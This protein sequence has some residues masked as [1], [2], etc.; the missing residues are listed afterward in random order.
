V[1]W[2]YG[3]PAAIVLFT[4]AL[5][6]LVGRAQDGAAE[7]RRQVLTEVTDPA[8]PGWTA[9]TD[10]TPTMLLVQTDA[11]GQPTGL[12]VMALT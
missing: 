6:L 12:T 1:F 8:A 2:R 9:L 10:P 11:A 7:H 4:L 5:P 3:F